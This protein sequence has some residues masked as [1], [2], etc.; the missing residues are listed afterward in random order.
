[1]KWFLMP[2]A[3]LALAGCVAKN[4]VLTKSEWE[5]KYEDRAGGGVVFSLPQ[6]RLRF[7][8]VL[9]RKTFVAGVHTGVVDYCAK[10]AVA[11]GAKTTCA[12]L[13]PAGISES[14]RFSD[15][16]K[17]LCNADGGPKETRIVLADGGTLTTEFVPDGDETYVIPLQ[18]SY[19]QNFEVS[20]KLNANGTVGKGSL[21]TE[22]LGTQE[23]LTA[24]T[25]LAT[26]FE[27]AMLDES[28]DEPRKPESPTAAQIDAAASALRQLMA[29]RQTRDEIAARNT[30][31]AL[32]SRAV[33]LA[34]L[35]ARIARALADFVGEVRTRT[36]RE[37]RVHWI[38]R[39]TPQ[40]ERG[41]TEATPAALAGAAWI[42]DA[43]DACGEGSETVPSKRPQRHLAVI[44]DRK[45]AQLAPLA[46][47]SFAEATFAKARG[48]PYR[49]PREVDIAWYV[50]P[51][52]GT[53]DTPPADLEAA[54]CK[55]V[56]AVRQLL[57]Q[58]GI[59]LRLPE[60]TGGRKSAIAPEYHVDGSLKKLTITH[61]GESPAPL[62]TAAKA[63]LTP[64]TATPEPAEVAQLTAEASLISA[65][66]ALCRLVFSVAATDPLCLGPNPPTSRPDDG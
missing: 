25:E 62:I 4:E 15:P 35:D 49:I 9:N 37:D 47:G 12:T 21:T 26:K 48:W 66:Q 42:G 6:A 5:R 52:A 16:E 63:A 44:T 40:S 23:F 8:Y 60:K 45:E 3:V 36:E 31:D 34:A 33:Q 51:D 59:T 58:F 18:R 41:K 19:F 55:D 17:P 1:M 38:P 61:V 30:D 13:Q 39:P 53:S 65:R 43:F 14:L 56:D 50:C 28:A 32:P 57:P 27:L 22:N 29:L 2:V 7:D 54:K 64:E 24:F 20:L 10:G 46:S 11:A